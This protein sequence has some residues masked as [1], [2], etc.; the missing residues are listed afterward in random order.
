MS[1]GARSLGTD[2]ER[3]EGH[4]I[5]EDQNPSGALE[6]GFRVDVQMPLVSKAMNCSIVGT[7]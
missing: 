5:L 6:K 4:R 1:R 7:Q 3:N 2:E